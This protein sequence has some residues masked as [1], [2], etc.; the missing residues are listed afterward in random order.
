MS[1]RSKSNRRS[2]RKNQRSTPRPTAVAVLEREDEELDL[3]TEAQEEPSIEKEDVVDTA[4]DTDDKP[5]KKGFL[6]RR[7]QKKADKAEKADKSKGRDLNLAERAHLRLGAGGVKTL[8]FSLGLA[9]TLAVFVIIYVMLWTTISMIIPSVAAGLLNFSGTSPD[10]V[11]FDALMAVWFAP[12]LFV[13]FMIAAGEI[14]LMRKIWSLGVR[15]REELAA[16]LGVS[17]E[18]ESAEIDTKTTTQ[19]SKRSKKKEK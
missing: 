16:K 5:A 9:V 15:V 11:R 14:Y 12:L 19:S 4:G 17:S 8:N 7:R 6:A 2:T 13:V 1:N 18:K 3:D 10:T